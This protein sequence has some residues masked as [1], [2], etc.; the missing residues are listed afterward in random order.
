MHQTTHNVQ[1]A[2]MPRCTTHRPWRAHRCV[3]SQAPAA[4]PRRR[5][6]CSVWRAAA[7]TCAL[8]CC[9]EL[10]APCCI[11]SL[12]STQR[13]T[14]P[15]CSAY[16]LL[17]SCSFLD[18]VRIPNE[19]LGKQK[20]HVESVFSLLVSFS[21]I[22]VWEACNRVDTQKRSLVTCGRPTRGHCFPH[23]SHCVRVQLLQLCCHY[24]SAVLKSVR[25]VLKSVRASRVKERACEPC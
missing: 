5:R 13:T 8:A 19:Y 20:Q 16:H 15:Y 2:A 10:T 18:N 14:T 25:A 6:D 1:R 12:K 21:E 24:G 3:C 7:R 11:K 23:D 17:V 22:F 4:W 9:S